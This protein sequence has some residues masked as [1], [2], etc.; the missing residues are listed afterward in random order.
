MKNLFKNF[1]KN[2]FIFKGKEKLSKITI[3]FIV[4]LDIFIFIVLGLGVD[5]QV[6]VLNNPQVSFPSQCRT[7][8]NTKNIE[9]FNKYFYSKKNFNSRYQSIKND[10]MDS[11]CNTLLYTVIKAVHKEHNIL[12]LRTEEKRLLRELGK[13][14]KELTYIRKN[15]NTVLFEK[16]SS[17]TTDKSIIK[18]NISSE[19]I[20][21]RYD[22]YLKQND[23]LKK[24]KEDLLNFFK[25]STTIKELVLFA[26]TNKKQINKD[27]KNLRKAYAIKKELVTLA[28]LLPL[29]LLAFY[30]MRKFLEKERYILYIISKNILVVVFIPTFVSFITLVYTFLPKVF[31]EKVIKFFYELEIP[32]VVY[33]FAIALLVLL[34]GYLIIK[35]QK[36][37]KEE[38]EKFQD[39]DI[40]KIESYNRGICNACGNRVDYLI[41][42][43]CPCCQ[44]RLKIECETCKSKTIKG[45]KHCMSC[46]CEQK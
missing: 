36:K 34:F 4:T 30:L 14:S 24:K 23:E 26:E 25:N 2:N 18:D 32:F 40:S 8:I 19:N 13:V 21:A 11:R 39:N 5:F 22:R 46:G 29:L 42:D 20:K 31:I 9:N 12:E 7:I 1:Y 10:Q 44:N 45:L 28:F 41:M 35:I 27:Y 16:L 17:Q 37:Y 38:G 6:K 33:Y 15:Y 43:Y 3:L